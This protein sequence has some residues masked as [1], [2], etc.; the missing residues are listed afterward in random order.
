MGA[1]SPHFFLSSI[2]WFF[3]VDRFDTL[4]L[5]SDDLLYFMRLVSPSLIVPPLSPPSQLANSLR[6][7]PKSQRSWPQKW[8]Q[9]RR[10]WQLC[11]TA[12]H[13]KWKFKTTA[14]TT[15]W[16]LKFSL[17]FQFQYAAASNARQPLK[18]STCVKTRRN[19]KLDLKFIRIGNRTKIE[20]EREGKKLSRK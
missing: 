18:R 20:F 6:T 14:K 3:L 13:H 19:L 12:T 1:Y 2:M 15:R 8:F 16:F 7:K 9:Y 11:G 10:P 5:V 4:H 17:F